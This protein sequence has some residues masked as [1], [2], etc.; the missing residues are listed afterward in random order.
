LTSDDSAP[1][2]IV[3]QRIS[4]AMEA[5]CTGVICAVSDIA[6][7]RRIAP[8][9]TVVTPGI[10]MDGAAIND[11]KRVATPV[12]AFE[13]GSDLLVV[14]RTV[15]AAASPAAAAEALIASLG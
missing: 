2:H 13:A 15:T 8:R 12:A 9:F 3:P 11:Q 10:R 7:V 4:M 14:G 5:G 6:D 1:P